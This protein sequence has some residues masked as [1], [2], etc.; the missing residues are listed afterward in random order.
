MESPRILINEFVFT[1]KSKQGYTIREAP[2][3]PSRSSKSLSTI[4]NEYESNKLEEKSEKALVTELNSWKNTAE[5]YLSFDIIKEANH[6]LERRIRHQNLA[7]ETIKNRKKVL[8]IKA[9]S[10][11]MFKPESSQVKT[12][13]RFEEEKYKEKST[14]HKQYES[15]L[16]KNLKGF[17]DQLKEINDYREGLR[18]EISE[19]RNQLRKSHDELEICR[20][21]LEKLEK[22]KK[23][24]T[25]QTGAATYLSRRA[26]IREEINSKES[27]YMIFNEEL[28]QEITKNMRMIDDLDQKC[29]VLRKEV[30]IIK[31]AQKKHFRAVL[32]EGKDTRNEGL[33]WI[34]KKLWKLEENMA[35]K[36]FP[37]FLEERTIEAIIKIASKSKEIEDYL[38]KI[39]SGSFA[40]T[41]KTYSKSLGIKEIQTRIA[42]VSKSI[43]IKR[44]ETVFSE[45]KKSILW[46]NLSPSDFDNKYKGMTGLLVC[47]QKIEKLKDEIKE[48]QDGEIQRMLKECFLNYYDEKKKVDIRTLI[49]TLVGVDNLDKYTAFVIKMKRDLTEKLNSTRTFRFSN[50]SK[51]ER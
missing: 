49:A 10:S 38:Y 8:P 18:T 43:Q 39:S 35:K 15:E 24:L 40:K 41:G 31:D 23:F 21:D 47:E 13:K 12:P 34:V 5:N 16:D 20:S 2:Y 50:G 48:I 22:H 36:D 46:E 37:C 30:K 29:G 9:T 32:L 27:R 7:E 25:V 3:H 17:E 19:M 28:T 14:F 45:S 11:N 26:S 51:S 6:L 44:T 33:Q 42:E 1:P 4:C